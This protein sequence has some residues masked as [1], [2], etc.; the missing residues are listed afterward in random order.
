MADLTCSG[1]IQRMVSDVRD[2]LVVI[3]VSKST[4][5]ACLTVRRATP[6]QNRVTP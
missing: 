6:R 1:D 3:D 5:Q 4:S 2:E